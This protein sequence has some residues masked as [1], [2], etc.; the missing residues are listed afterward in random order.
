VAPAVFGGFT[1]SA[2][3]AEGGYATA[4]LALPP[5]WRL[6]FGVPDYD[7]P[8]EKAR[9]ALPDTSTARRRPHR[10]PR[11]ALWALAVA[12]DEPELLRTASI[13]VLHE[14]YREALVPGLRDVRAA[15]RDAGAYA[16]FLSGAGPRSGPSSR[17]DRGRLPR[18]LDGFVGPRGRVLALRSAGGYEIVDGPSGPPERAD[19]RRPAFDSAPRARPP[20]GERPLA[21]GRDV[22]V[23]A[24]GASSRSYGRARLTT[25]QATPPGR[26]A[27]WAA[28]TNARDSAP[29]TWRPT[30][31]GGLHQT[32]SKPPGPAGARRG[33]GRSRSAWTPRAP[34]ARVRRRRSAR[35]P[36]APR[37]GRRRPPPRLARAPRRRPRQQ[38]GAAPQVEQPG[39]RRLPRPA[40][41]G[42][43]AR[44]S[45]AVPGSTF[46]AAKVPTIAPP[47][48]PGRVER[49]HG[50]AGGPG[51]GRRS[52]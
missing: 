47:A 43:S 36:S 51:R 1:V 7:L 37:R 12:R 16:A 23:R 48:P 28:A 17:G 2:P 38:A 3:R 4:V 24:P 26:S 46:S 35:P 42:A 11:A 13:D 41:A 20:H 30:W 27:W 18:V 33:R 6:L 22:G 9:A 40:A 49:A 44:S 21:G 39:A 8:T 52:S 45:T 29:T 34:R 14:P 15:L 25:N 5:G 50:S 31:K 10:G 32:T 19:A